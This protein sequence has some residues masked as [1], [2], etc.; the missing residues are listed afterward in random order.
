MKQIFSS[1]KAFYTVSIGLIVSS[2]LTTLS[3]AVTTHVKPEPL[4]LVLLFALLNIV[5][6]IF[7]FLSIYIL[8]FANIVMILANLKR[9]KERIYCYILSLIGIGSSFGM[10]IYI[11]YEMARMLQD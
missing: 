9:F 11:L 8:P 1:K 6:T 10:V 4:I 5:F 3:F 2:V 7:G